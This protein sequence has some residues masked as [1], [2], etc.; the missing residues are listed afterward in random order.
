MGN[1]TIY[2]TSAR[3][4]LRNVLNAQKA[5]VRLISISRLD[6]SGYKLS[7]ADGICTVLEH[8]SGR[9]LARCS[10]N[11]SNLYVLPGSIRSHSSSIPSFP[12]SFPCTA[13]PSLTA[14][15]NLE[16]WHRRHGIDALDMRT[17]EP[18]WTWHAAM[19]PQVCKST[20]TSSFFGAT[21]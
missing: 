3:L 6:D 11:S 19:S 21:W 10:R 4:T 2:E 12:F 9:T 5:G 7:F 14:K 17:S 15:P 16:T 13:F 1:Y 8:S 20:R 18:C